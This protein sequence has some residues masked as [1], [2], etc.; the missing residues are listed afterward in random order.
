MRARIVGTEAN[1][2]VGHQLYNYGKQRTERAQ[3]GLTPVA[4]QLMGVAT[5]AAENLAVAGISP[6][7][8]L[9]VL[10]AQGGAEAM[11]QSIDKG[12]SAGKTLVG[13]LAKFGAGWAINSVGAADLAKTMGSDYAKDTLAGKL[14]DMVRSVADN[15]VLAQQYPTVANA[16]SGGIDNA[17][18]AFVETYADKAIDAALGDAQAAE[19]MFSRDTFLQ[20]LESGLS[21]GASGALGGAVG[22][23]LGR[24]SAALETADGQTVQRNEPSQ[25]AKG[26]DSSPEGRAFETERQAAA[27]DRQVG[28]AAQQTE[29]AAVLQKE[30]APAASETVTEQT[31]AQAMQSDDPAVRQ[32]AQSEDVF[33]RQLAQDL[34]AGTVQEETAKFFASGVLSANARAEVE[35]AYGIRLPQNREEI[36]QALQ[37]IADRQAV[38][39][40]G[41]TTLQP[42]TAAPEASEKI[43]EQT[44][45]EESEPRGTGTELK[46]GAQMMQ[47]AGSTAE[48]RAETLPATA[49]RGENAGDTVESGQGYSVSMSNDTMTVRFADGTEAVRTV[50]PENPRTMLFDPDQLHRQAQ[51]ES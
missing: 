8:V 9:P 35:Q 40:A 44:A 50:D 31:A 43:A 28:N 21:G 7:L 24:M 23:Q 20:A 13:G 22:T 47:D 39:Q 27:N 51:A 32:L 4:K 6:A 36:R 16:V 49:Q 25:A 19:E 45:Q 42:Q 12:E 14:A 3:A 48:R 11:G 17:M 2:S 29:D 37:G 18:Q 26:A 33:V 34:A 5:S 46:S 10:S 41:E 1:E 38:Q 15:G 30:T